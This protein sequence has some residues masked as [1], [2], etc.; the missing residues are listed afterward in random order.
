MRIDNQDIARMARELCEEENSQLHVRRW[1]HRRHFTLPAWLAAVPAAAIVGFL[2]GL[3]TNSR[4]TTGG[5]LTAMTDTVYVT[6]REPVPTVDT[7]YMPTPPSSPSA[8]PA[9]KSSRRATTTSH[10]SPSTGH[11]MANDHIRYDLLVKN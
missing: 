5:P 2:L 7:V 1:G 8:Q 3:W 6:V 4:L 10:Q 9:S 11:S